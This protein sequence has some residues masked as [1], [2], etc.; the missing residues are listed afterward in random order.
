MRRSG[1]GDYFG[2]LAP[3]LKMPRTAT[4][5]TNRPTVLLAMSGAELRQYLSRRASAAGGTALAGHPNAS[6]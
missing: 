3:V 2:E 4:A 6:G 1:P 5:R